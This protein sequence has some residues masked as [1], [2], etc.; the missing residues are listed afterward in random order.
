MHILFRTIQMRLIKKLKFKNCT[1]A[2][3]KPHKLVGEY[4]AKVVK[5]YDGDTIT[6]VMDPYGKIERF[7]IR[8]WGIDAPEMRS[9][10]LLERNAAQRVQEVLAFRIMNKTVK[11]TCKGFDK[12]GR[13]LASVNYRDV[14]YAD[15]LISNKYV[16]VYLGK[17]KLLWKNKEF[18]DIVTPPLS[19]TREFH[20]NKS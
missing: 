11:L 3:T 18:V 10:N 17:R 8:I 1:Y 5:V 20:D 16:H 14:D 12:Y 6:V 4:H 2:N 7:S 15:W 13:V 19:D 9:S